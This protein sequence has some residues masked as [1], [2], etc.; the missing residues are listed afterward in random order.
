LFKRTRFLFPDSDNVGDD[1]ESVVVDSVILIPT[2]F[3]RLE[4]RKLLRTA[5]DCLL[6]VN[7]NANS[8]AFSMTMVI[9][10]I[11]AVPE[12]SKAIR[13]YRS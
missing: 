13:I 4:L 10:L 7:K 1:L 3:S 8:F 9:G 5:V 12:R 2:M 6:I 11:V